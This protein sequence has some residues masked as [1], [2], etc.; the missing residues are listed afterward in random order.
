MPNGWP[1]LQNYRIDGRYTIDD[2]IAE[3]VIRLFTVNRK[4]SLFYSSEQGLDVAAT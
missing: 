4:N 3:H 2:I 1:E